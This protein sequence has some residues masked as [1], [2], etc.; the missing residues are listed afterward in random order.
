MVTRRARPEAQDD[1]S[2]LG[3]LKGTLDTSFSQLNPTAPLLDTIGR[4]L[5][6]P[7]PNAIEWVVGK[8]WCNVPSTYAISGQYQT[9][10][11]FFELR[12]PLCNEGGIDPGEPGDCMLMGRAALEAEALLV[13]ADAYQEDVCPRCGTT[14]S[15]LVEDGFFQGYNTLHLVVGQRA[16]K[17]IAAGLIGTYIEHRILTLALSTKDGFGAYL[18]LHIKDPFEM[19]FL[20]STDTQSQDTIWAKYTAIRAESPW[21]QR[22]VPWV[23]EQEEKQI[24]PD[25]MKRWFYKE[26]DKRI[27]NM[28]PSVRLICNSLNSNAPGLRG[29]TRP[30]AFAD[31][32]SHMEQ[33][34]SKRSAT[35]I[36]RSLERSLRTVRTRTKLYGGLPW[37]GSMFSVTSPVSRNDKGMQLLRDAKKVKTMY[38][39]QLATWDFNPLEP[40]AGLDDEFAKDPIGA[41]RD[42]G[43]IPP[44]A[45]YPLIHDEVR[46][47]QEA[48]RPDLQ[49]RA[50]FEIYNRLSPTGQPYVA[51]KV[52]HADFTPGDRAPRFVV[53]DAGK[54][55]DAFS[56]ACAHAEFL[57]F[58]DADPT[59]TWT[60]TPGGA[61]G[62]MVTVFDWVVR[63][64]PMAGTEV[65]FESVHEVMARLNR[66]VVMA[67]CEF[68]RWQSVQLIQQVRELGIFAEQKPTTDKDYVQFKID[69]YEG[70]CQLLPPTPGDIDPNDDTNR[71]FDWQREPPDMDAQSCGIYE[72]LGAQCDP[73]TNKVT[74][75]EKGD[76]R[77]WGSN[78][79]CQ[80]L[81]HAHTLVQ[82]HASGFTDR[83]DDRSVRAARMRAE[84]SGADWDRRGFIAKMPASAQHG[85]R[86]WSSGGKRGW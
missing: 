28:H 42:Y 83:H 56:G 68:D 51:V 29:R 71:P 76:R 17:S 70:L 36:Y 45:E 64:L 19:T 62:R 79:T 7:A 33:T 20:A 10:R 81:V 50:E 57:P 44:G 8:D 43:A 31:E 24:V 75:P 37:L 65:Y 85:V 15:E 26:S 40:R 35:E 55:F 53:W 18:G 66:I 27:V 22:Y 67:R 80:V 48:I 73:D 63:V 9:I 1:L 49:A 41:K 16:G 4:G 25:G 13:W 54:N 38:A 2:W 59:P 84:A 6:T 12:C 11:D 74:F 21:F 14:R 30:A 69:C 34:D 5:S 46:F 77:G 52:K 32:I 61:R 39:R 82:R 72:L 78:D 58:P 3:D 47:R 23:K 60:R 86:N